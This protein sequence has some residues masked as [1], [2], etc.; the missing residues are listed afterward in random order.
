MKKFLLIVSLLLTLALAP[1]AMAQGVHSFSTAA[2]APDVGLVQA[3][4][5]IS[6]HKLTWVP[7]GTVSTCQVSLDTSADNSSWS[8]G[9]AI[10]AQTC[11]SAGASLV[12]NVNANF[13]RINVTTISGGGTVFVTWNGYVNNPSGAFS[14]GSG[15]SFQDILLT[16]SPGNPASGYDR[17]YADSGT[18]NVTCL[19]SSGGS[20][21]SGGGAGTVTVVGGGSLAATA[22]VTGGGTTTLQTPSATSTL[23][24]SGNMSLAGT[25]TAIGSI[26]STHVAG[27]AGS[28]QTVG[29]VANPALGS[30]SFAWGAP[31]SAS[32]TSFGWNPPT[33]ENGSAGILH[34][35]AASSHWSPLTISLVSMTADIT[36]VTPVA[37]GGTNCS[38][39]TIT[40]FNNIT[41]FTA[42]GTT[43]TTSTNV[44]FSTSPTLVTPALGAATATSLLATGIVDG[45]VPVTVT[46]GTTANLGTTY[47]SGYTFNQ[48][49]TPGTG[50]TYTLPATALGLQ[51]CVQNSGTTAG[52]PDTGVLTVYPPSGSYVILAGVVNTIGGG[53]T[54]GVVSGGAAGDGACFVAIDAT[55]WQVLVLSGAWAEN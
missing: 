45:T 29:D 38:S 12:V 51:Y 8:V 25:L 35:G 39:A 3:Q 36:G 22:I 16:T 6:Y 33:A 19:T 37:N 7:T 44:V 49:A 13:V 11:T 32:F 4:T 17:L 55:H 46:T 47:K 42:A 27:T 2:V 5:G 14:G 50:V 52:G 9:G 43:G 54:H 21:L 34:V 40:C 26:T 23:N 18:G 1:S 53:G 20:C 10:T 28:A 15:S 31:L 30:N 48:E 41:G 24:S